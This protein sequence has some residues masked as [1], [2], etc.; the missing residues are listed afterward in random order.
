MNT[1]SENL[2]GIKEVIVQGPFVVSW[3]SLDGYVT[4]AF[5][6]IMGDNLVE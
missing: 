5:Q 6:I 4:T 1:I 3:D 2:I